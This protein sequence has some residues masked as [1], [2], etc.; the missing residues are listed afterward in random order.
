M[1]HE[2]AHHEKVSRKHF[3]LDV[4]NEENPCGPPDNPCLNNGRCKEDNSEDGYTCYCD[5]GFTGENCEYSK[6]IHS[7]SDYV[8]ISNSAKIPHRMTK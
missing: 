3:N 2:L 1:K 5:K 8:S 6:L 7:Y 4:F